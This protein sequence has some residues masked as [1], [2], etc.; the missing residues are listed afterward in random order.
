MPELN[1]C[2]VGH[3]MMGVWHSEALAGT[4]TRL[5]TV[6]GRRAEPTAA[7]AARYGYDRWTLELAEAL[8]DPAL[9][10]IV[11]ANPTELHAETALACI[12]AGK[13]TLLEIP[14]AMSLA[15]AE[16]VVEAAERAGVPLAMVHPMRF[17]PECAP[18]LER[19]AAGEEHVRHVSA[20]FFIHRLANVGATG[21]RR[22]WTDNLLWHHVTHLVD[23]GLWTLEAGGSPVR[24]VH[25]FM[26]PCDPGTGIPM[27]AVVL[28][29]TEADQSLVCTG[30]Y[31][32]RERIYDTFVVTDRDSYRIDVLA[33]TLT[34]GDGTRAVDAEQANCA[35][36]TRDFVEALAEGRAPAVTGRSVLP[37]MRALQQVQDAWDE[38]HGETAL[39]GRPL[40]A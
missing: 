11:V 7:F 14:I 13:A 25:G 27:E 5:H 40:P 22:S 35:Y 21:Y 18:L 28:V 31:F 2:M 6:V 36:A 34:T 37:A 3:G 4:G 17:R 32:A 38:R 29:E 19:V 20:R 33:G 26:P 15:D 1:L 8:A 10:A 16:R 12:A 30:S 24:H 39:P 23:F 9:D